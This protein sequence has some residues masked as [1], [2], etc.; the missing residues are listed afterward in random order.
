M[1]LE[2]IKY[3]GTCE[4]LEDACFRVRFPYCDEGTLSS[5]VPD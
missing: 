2:S 5:S 1:V 3:V 4:L